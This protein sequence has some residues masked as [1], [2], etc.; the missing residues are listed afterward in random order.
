MRSPLMKFLTTFPA[1]YLCDQGLKTDNNDLNYQRRPDMQK[2]S[3]GTC[4]CDST[5]NSNVNSFM[6]LSS[7]FVFLRNV[8]HSF[9]KLNGIRGRFRRALSIRSYARQ[10]VVL[11]VPIFYYLSARKNKCYNKHLSCTQCNL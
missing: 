10:Y 4:T 9:K 11:D 2:K 5:K 6:C 7:S 8:M 1:T 3:L